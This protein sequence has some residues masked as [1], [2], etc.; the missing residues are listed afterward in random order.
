[1]PKKPTKTPKVKKASA[2]DARIILK[3]YD[4][5]REARL[6]EARDFMAA[7]FWPETFQDVLHLV[8][9][10]GTEQN[11]HFRQA[12]TYW[13]MAASLVVHGALDY[14][15]FLSNSGEM[16]FY[17]AKLKPFLRDIREKIGMKTYFQ[18]IEKVC[19]ST[20]KS[21]ERLSM[22]EQSIAKMAQM[23]KAAAAG[24]GR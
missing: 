8:G 12:L 24:S 22:V 19:E 9:T 4:L 10:P 17:Y 14:D 1:M 13:E 6:R 5:R 23:R 2:E 20:P 3:L 16:Y 21:R 15:L 11:R 7:E 18:N